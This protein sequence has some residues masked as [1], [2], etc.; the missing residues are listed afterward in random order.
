MAAR[1]RLGAFVREVQ[2]AASQA[3][4]EPFDGG[5]LAVLAEPYGDPPP[6]EV[7]VTELD[8]PGPALTAGGC[9]VVTGDALDPVLE[10][11][12]VASVET[13][14]TADGEVLRLA[15]RPLLPHERTC[16]DAQ[17]SVVPPSP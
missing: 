17:E 9:T 8:W 16:E 7:T 6:A 2:D 11:A 1:E 4:A 14:W 3:P 10:A 12:G 15:F 13:R 5:S